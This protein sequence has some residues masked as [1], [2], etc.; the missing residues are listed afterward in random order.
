MKRYLAPKESDSADLLDVLLYILTWENHTHGQGILWF[1][2]LVLVHILC[3]TIYFIHVYKIRC[4]VICMLIC[5][6]LKDLVS[7]N[8]GSCSIVVMLPVHFGWGSWTL[9]SRRTFKDSPPSCT[10]T[11][12]TI[13]CRSAC[14]RWWHC[15]VQGQLSWMQGILV[16]NWLVHYCGT[17]AGP[18]CWGSEMCLI[19]QIVCFC[20]DWDNVREKWG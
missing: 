10:H 1:L 11:T 15:S 8:W 6:V 5:C 19:W 7:L 13:Q 12:C 18:L 16:V 17:I 2:F 14:P 3:K 4:F 20:H 9:H